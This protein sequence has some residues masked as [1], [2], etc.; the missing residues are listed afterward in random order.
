MDG[1]SQN[2]RKEVRDDL[3]E[4]ISKFDDVDPDLMRMSQ[5]SSP[6]LDG[7]GSE[8]FE[9]IE[10]ERE[11]IRQEI[12]EKYDLTDEDDEEAFD[13]KLMQARDDGALNGLLL[14]AYMDDSGDAYW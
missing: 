13:R 9:K 4:A 6:L 10:E 12:L 11:R 7:P 8:A 1:Y 2:E 14:D 3:E 5:S